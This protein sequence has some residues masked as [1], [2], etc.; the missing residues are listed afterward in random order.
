MH[1]DIYA[2]RNPTHPVEPL[3]VRRWS[4]RA[5]SR[6]QLTDAELSTLLEAARWAPSCFNEQPWRFL[7][8]HRDTQHWSLYLD[9]L[10]DANQSWAKNA[11][12][13]ITVI[14]KLAF[15]R[16]SN[17]N[18]THSLDTGAAW[19][20]LALQATAMGLVAHGMAGFDY[21]KARQK[22]QIPEDYSVEMMIAVGRPGDPATLP[23]VLQERE[24]PSSRV[25]ISEF[26]FA[27]T[28]PD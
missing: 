21:A 13:L 2:Y 4:P 24:Q 11:S 23:D 3:L 27:G 28:F 5:M 1:T 6:E 18:T 17:H 10:A 16:N 7:Y 15:S 12:V 25:E 8:A 19:Q 20:N 22:L 14:S 9:L 26:S